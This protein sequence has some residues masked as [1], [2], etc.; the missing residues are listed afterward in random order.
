[1][2]HATTSISSDL[3]GFNQTQICDCNYANMCF[4]RAKEQSIR[5]TVCVRKCSLT[6]CTA[7]PMFYTRKCVYKL[8]KVVSLYPSLNY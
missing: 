4:N 3:Y 8:Y 5:I 1:M 6:V 7:I 2:S